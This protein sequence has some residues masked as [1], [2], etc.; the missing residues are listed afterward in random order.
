MDFVDYVQYMALSLS[1][2]A[3]VGVLSFPKLNIIY[4]RVSSN[5]GCCY[6]THFYFQ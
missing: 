3:L 6:K 1:G 2:S 5:S 4:P